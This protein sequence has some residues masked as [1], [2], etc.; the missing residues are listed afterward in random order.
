MSGARPEARRR[1]L[2]LLLAVVDFMRIEL[3]P[4]L[5]LKKIELDQRHPRFPRS[6][7]V[8]RSA[9]WATE[10]EEIERTTGFA[11]RYCDAV[12]CVSHDGATPPGVQR[13]QEL[14]PMKRCPDKNTSQDIA[15]ILL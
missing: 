14:S 8:A 2:N 7:L 12:A 9:A 13:R 15:K 11:T 3:T 5:D 6:E 1:A 4:A 10:R